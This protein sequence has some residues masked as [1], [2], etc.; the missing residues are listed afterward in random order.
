M[1][2][3]TRERV[4]DDRLPFQTEERVDVL[5]S[6]A[7]LRAEVRDLKAKLRDRDARLRAARKKV[8]PLIDWEMGEGTR[9][10]VYDPL[11]DV[12]PMLDTRRKDWRGK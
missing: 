9:G 5:D 2:R 8:E 6:E 10:A 4:M 12:L 11:R 3:A 7:K 1:R